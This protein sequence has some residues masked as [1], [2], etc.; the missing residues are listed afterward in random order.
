MQDAMGNLMDD[1]EEVKLEFISLKDP[2]EGLEARM[3]GALNITIGTMQEQFGVLE[4][5]VEALTRENQELRAGLGWEQALGEVMRR[6]GACEVAAAQG[7]RQGQPAGRTEAPKPRTFNGARNAREIDNWLY[8]VERYFDA[9][10]LLDEASKLRTIPLYLGDVP[11]L[12]W[13]RVTEDIARGR[14]AAIITWQGF[15][16]ELK[17][18]FYPESA[19]DEA[20]AKLRHLKQG[21]TIREY[22]KEFTELLLEIPDISDSDVLFSFTD[23][24]QGW[25][26]LELEQ[27]GI[28][29]LADNIPV[30]E[31]LIKFKRESRKEKS[32][33]K[34]DDIIGEGVER[35]NKGKEPGKGSKGMGGQKRPLECFICD[36]PHMARECPSRGKLAAMLIQGDTAEVD[37]QQNMSAMRLLGAVDAKAEASRK[38]PMFADI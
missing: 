30:A 24:L 23:G 32:N 16:D 28:Q 1:L 38:G 19:T 35:D 18:Q 27:R 3:Q 29:N 6:L 8:Q 4:A 20:R 17:R 31:S 26:K 2:E 14:R 15:K 10:F 12:W 36:G 5:R 34:V 9:A 21:G 25:V 37:R 22:V 11:T 33:K 7:A 13:R